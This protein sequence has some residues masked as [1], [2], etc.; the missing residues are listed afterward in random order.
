MGTCYYIVIIFN[1]SHVKN[2]V[3]RLVNCY[4]YGVIEDFL[5][6]KLCVCVCMCVYTECLSLVNYQIKVRYAHVYQEYCM[7]QSVIYEKGH[8]ARKCIVSHVF[9]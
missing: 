3:T 5:L 4:L 7:K 2:F 8:I 6:L 1:Y 9:Q